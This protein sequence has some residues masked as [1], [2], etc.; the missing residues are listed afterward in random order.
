M[1]DCILTLSSME[2]QLTTYMKHDQKPWRLKTATPLTPTG[3]STDFNRCEMND[4]K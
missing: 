3:T 4:T 1:T 2:S